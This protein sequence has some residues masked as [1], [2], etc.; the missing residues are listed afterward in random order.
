MTM[1]NSVH[2]FSAWNSH[3]P[4]LTYIADYIDPAAEKILTDTIDAEPWLH[5]LK[6]RVQHYGYRYDYKARGVARE[7][8]LAP[9]PEWIAAYCKRLY[10]AKLF[11]QLPDQVI[12]NE[13]LPSQGIA[14]HIDCIPCF[15]NT[16]ASLSLGSPCVMEFSHKETGEKIPMLLEPRS[17][18]LLSGDARYQWRHGIAHRK[19]D[20]FN[21]NVFK[22]GRRLSL[23]FRKVI[24]SV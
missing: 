10:T 11:P 2:G 8:K 16:I 1:T 6:R 4:G 3:I 23:T 15:E 20:R 22:R 24:L 21:G 7:S 9:L 13:Y 18:V 5:D 19:T 14:P 17:L 12:V